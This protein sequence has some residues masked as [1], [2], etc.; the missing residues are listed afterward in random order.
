MELLA[1]AATDA[2]ESDALSFKSIFNIG[3]GVFDV[4]KDLIGGK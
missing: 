1:R 4:G 2:D 3:K